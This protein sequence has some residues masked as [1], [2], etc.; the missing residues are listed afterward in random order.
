ML[1]YMIGAQAEGFPMPDPPHR[2]PECDVAAKERQEAIQS[3]VKW[4]EGLWHTDDMHLTDD[5]LN[6]GVASV[7][8]LQ[9]DPPDLTAFLVG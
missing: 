9:E 3:E 7:T 5:E 1:T 8:M 2:C 6:A 4:L